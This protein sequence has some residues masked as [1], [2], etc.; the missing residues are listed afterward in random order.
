MEHFGDGGTK[1]RNKLTQIQNLSK[2]KKIQ[3][4]G[5]TVLAMDDLGIV[6]TWGNGDTKP[7]TY[8]KI[9][10]RV[11]DISAGRNQNAFVTT[12]GKVLGFGNILNRRS[13]RYY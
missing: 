3:A 13:S 1:N 5:N 12:K 8:E 4:G 10:V 2:I 6:Y 7:K 9:T 11:I